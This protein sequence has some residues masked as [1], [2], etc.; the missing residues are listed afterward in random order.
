[1][2]T[3]REARDVIMAPVI[4]E[5]SYALLEDRRY[6][7]RVHPLAQKTEIRKAVEE[8]FGVTVLSVNT[9]NRP[10][11]RKR[12]RRSGKFGTSP[13]RKHDIVHLAEGDVIE[14]FQA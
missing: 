14:L 8:I 13:T 10:G 3:K 11:K 9:I 5:K 4:S 12:D 2:S 6:T 1:M 7:F